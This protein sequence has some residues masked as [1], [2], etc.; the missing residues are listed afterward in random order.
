MR[1]HSTSSRKPLL[2]CEIKKES[3]LV[4]VDFADGNTALFHSQW[5]YHN[6]PA[7]AQPGSGQ[8]ATPL[9]Q[10]A[11]PPALSA[12]AAA[13]DGTLVVTWADGSAASFTAAW[14]RRHDYSDG[15]LARA[16]AA[17]APP[18]LTAAAPRP[19][20]GALGKAGL[21]THACADLLGDDAAVLRWLRDLDEWGIALVTGAGVAGG[22]AARLAAR[23]APPMRTLYGTEWD[24]EVQPGV[25]PI[26]IGARAPEVV[27]GG[28]K[29]RCA[30]PTS[31]ARDVGRSGTEDGGWRARRDVVF[32]RP[33]RSG[34]VL[35]V[36]FRYGRRG[37][38]DWRP[39]D[40]TGNDGDDD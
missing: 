22:T 26:N 40:A 35:L 34:V 12:A 20:G 31:A 9:Q 6:S 30:P 1:R 2:S 10:L 16:A 4:K 7:H 14:L 11:R 27:G 38:D 39:V 17:A 28:G 23:I 25:A 32:V 33:Q 24:V 21:P 29:G 3:Q 19:G 13:T 5:L 37:G 18:C 36:V 15:A 8:R